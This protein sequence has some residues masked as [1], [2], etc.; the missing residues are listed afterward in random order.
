MI[1]GDVYND[2]YAVNY[3]AS[4]SAFDMERCIYK[5]LIKSLP[6]GP[7]RYSK[8][9]L[10]DIEP[11]HSIFRALESMSRIVVSDRT[12]ELLQGK[13]VIGICFVE[14]RDNM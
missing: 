9:V 7:K 5:P 13:S 14:G 4:E 6:E 11:T 12:V 10:Q 3:L 2:Y 8:I 1:N